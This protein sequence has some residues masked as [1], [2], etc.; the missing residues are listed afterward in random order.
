MFNC[1]ICLRFGAFSLWKLHKET[2]ANALFFRAFAR[3]NYCSL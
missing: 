1:A 2:R 3:F